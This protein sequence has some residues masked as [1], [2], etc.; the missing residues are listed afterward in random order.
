MRQVVGFAFVASLAVAAPAIGKVRRSRKRSLNRQHRP[1]P[2]QMKWSA[3]ESRRSEAAFR[4]TR[5][6]IRARSGCKSV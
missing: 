6:A 4:L 2:T 5:F 3:K 1:R